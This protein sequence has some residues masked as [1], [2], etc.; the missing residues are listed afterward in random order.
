MMVSTSSELYKKVYSEIESSGMAK[1]RDDDKDTRGNGDG[2]QPP[3]EG[4]SARDESR[5][6]SNKRPWF[7]KDGWKIGN[8][9]MK[10]YPDE[11]YDDIEDIDIATTK[12]DDDRDSR[13]QEMRERR[14]DTFSIRGHDVQRKTH[15]LDLPTADELEHYAGSN[16]ICRSLVD[17]YRT[18]Y[19][20]VKDQVDE[21]SKIAADIDRYSNYK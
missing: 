21:L 6:E 1:K 10:R 4:D 14:E 5:D 7:D 18:R 3:G 9:R 19:R 2:T 16:D 11:T 13:P 8:K 17:L 15:W 12:G 20:Q